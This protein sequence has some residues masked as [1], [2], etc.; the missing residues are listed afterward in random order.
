MVGLSGFIFDRVYKKRENAVECEL[1]LLCL[2]IKN[3]GRSGEISIL[4]L[5][6][7]TMV[8]TL[9]I[10]KLFFK[11][12]GKGG[13]KK[14]CKWLATEDAEDRKTGSKQKYYKKIVKM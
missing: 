6:F 10:F 7:T 2:L 1:L 14:N 12:C 11:T 8:N 9:V 5:I 13:E 3:R 4:N